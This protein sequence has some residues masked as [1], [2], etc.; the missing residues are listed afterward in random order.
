MCGVGEGR[1]KWNT[2]KTDKWDRT[3]D[4]E[5]DLRKYAQLSFDKGEK[6]FN[7]EEKAFSINGAGASGLPYT[8]THTHTKE[9]Q[10]KSHTLY[11][12]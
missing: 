9:P 7:S 6:Q 8:H 12:N 4:P 5:I 1:G 10:S 2:V 11:K 3:K